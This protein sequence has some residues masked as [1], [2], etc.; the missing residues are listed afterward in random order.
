MYFFATKPKN[1]VDLSAGDIIVDQDSGDLF[2]LSKNPK[3][4]AGNGKMLKV[5]VTAVH[6][7][8]YGVEDTYNIEYD[9]AQPTIN[10]F[11]MVDVLTC[12]HSDFY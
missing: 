10:N 3:Y 11:R 9:L 2:Q 7:D 12:E 4:I 8:V 5:A 6:T 1:V